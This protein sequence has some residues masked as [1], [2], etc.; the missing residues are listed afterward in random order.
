METKLNYELQPEVINF[1]LN[2]LNKTTFTGVNDAKNL[3]A[4]IEILQK[5]TNA[6]DLEKEQYE[7][8]KEKFN[9]N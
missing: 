8:L 1:I 5:P 9:N 7:K 3:L 4:V 2:V 6:N